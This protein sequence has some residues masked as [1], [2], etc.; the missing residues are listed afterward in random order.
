MLISRFAE[1]D[2]MKNSSF[3]TYEGRQIDPLVIGLSSMRTKVYTESHPCPSCGDV[4]TGV[5]RCFNCGKLSCSDIMCGCSCPGSARYSS[6]VTI[7]TRLDEQAIWS[8]TR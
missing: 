4:G 3:V 8:T 6:P 1:A 5:P 7:I 2:R